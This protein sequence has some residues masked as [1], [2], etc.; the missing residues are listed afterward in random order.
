MRSAGVGVESASALPAV[1]NFEVAADEEGFGEVIK[2]SWL[3]EPRAE[4][5]LRG[6]SILVF[7]VFI[8][9][10]SSPFE[11]TKTNHPPHGRPR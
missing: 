6:T 8:P 1:V 3:A 2:A 7:F 11:C 9:R 5:C 4:E 10:L